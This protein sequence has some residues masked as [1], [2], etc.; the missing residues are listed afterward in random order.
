MLRAQ[1]RIARL[2]LKERAIIHILWLGEEA[3]AIVESH[4]VRTQERERRTRHRTNP[5]AHAIRPRLDAE[6]GRTPL[7]IFQTNDY[8]GEKKKFANLAKL[9]PGR[10]RQK[11]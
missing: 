2:S 9:Q 4:Q 6:A 11:S 8:R 7:P 5:F 3:E 10:A 1:K